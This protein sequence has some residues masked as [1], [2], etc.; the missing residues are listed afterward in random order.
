[1]RNY[2]FNKGP[3]ADDVKSETRNRSRS[4][5]RDGK[6][7][8]NAFATARAKKVFFVYNES[9]RAAASL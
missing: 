3:D 5:R 8:G 1:M 9:E 4:L 2:Q 6:G 7:T